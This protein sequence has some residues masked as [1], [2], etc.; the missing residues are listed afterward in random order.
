MSPQDRKRRLALRPAESTLDELEREYK[1]SRASRCAARSTSWR[2]WASSERTRGLGTFVAKDLSEQR[3]FKLASR[4]EE[5]VR[6]VADL[7]IRLLPL[8][9][10]ASQPLA[11]AFDFGL[12]GPAYERLRR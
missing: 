4:M 12:P 6:T 1:V 3:W 11:P 10:D 5:L 7:K 2:R 8:Q 9:G